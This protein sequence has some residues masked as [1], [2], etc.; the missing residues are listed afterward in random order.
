[1]EI[2]SII[3]SNKKVVE[4]FLEFLNKYQGFDTKKEESEKICFIAKDTKS[5]EL[6]CYLKDNIDYELTFN[7]SEE[8]LIIIESFFNGKKIYLMDCSFKRKLFFS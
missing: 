6:C 1:M 5:V 3:Y 8:S 2:T 7:F 4:I